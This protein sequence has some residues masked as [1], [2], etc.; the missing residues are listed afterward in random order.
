MSDNDW[1]EFLYSS[2]TL[3]EYI[4][5]VRRENRNTKDEIAALVRLI[6]DIAKY[7][8]E[9]S[10]ETFKRLALLCDAIQMLLHSEL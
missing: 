8:Y 6:R 1:P 5:L 9:T 3:E 4:D 10:E 7:P 2:L